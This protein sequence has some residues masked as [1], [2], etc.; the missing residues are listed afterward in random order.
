MTRRLLLT[1]GPLTTSATVK[2]AMGRDL[3]SR[4]A[5]F[6][7]LTASIRRRILALA[8]GED[9]ARYTTVLLQGSGTFVVEAMLGTLVPREGALLV[10]ENGAYGRR[11]RELAT[12]IGRRVE[13]LSFE[14]TTPV[15]PETVR[16]ALASRPHITH[17]AVVQ[18]E[19]TTGL[20]NPVDAVADVVY[21]AGKQ[22]LVD[23]MSA[24][25]ALAPPRR[26]LALAASSNKCL[27][28]V[29]GVGFCVAHTDALAAAKGNAHSV[30]LDLEAQWR[31]FEANGQWRFTP[32]T[33]VLLALGQALD[34]LE[35][36]G[37][38]PA[39]GRRYAENARV[40]IDGMRS[41]GL[42]PIL[43]DAVQAPIIV[44]FASPAHPRFAFP[45]FYDA[46]ASRG[47]VI[48]PGKLT[49]AETFRVGCIGRLDATDIQRAVAAVREVLGELEVTL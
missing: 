14:E 7:Q 4:D 29:P 26:F 30:S 20:L 25:G 23:A 39:R 5:D 42:S 27:E 2:A 10:L 16:A 8:R 46:L 19:T 38:V 49:E 13:S 43:A 11:L 28:G 34:E 44:T 24:F 36:E 47:F 45:A 18:C 35:A 3:G 22:L 32:P 9:A 40:L 15:D 33:H 1:P 48:Y 21:G 17:V 37:G 31:G 12:R 6:I 41:L